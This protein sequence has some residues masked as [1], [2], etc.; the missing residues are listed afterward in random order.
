MRGFLRISYRAEELGDGMKARTATLLVAGGIALATTVSSPAGA[1]TPSPSPSPTGSAS[2]TASVFASVD[3]ADL[4][5]KIEKHITK[6]GG[7]RTGPNRISWE[8]QGVVMTFPAPAQA[9][10]GAAADDINYARIH[11]SYGN[12]CLYEHAL[13][14]RE[15]GAMIAFYDYN[16]YQLSDYGWQDIV[17]ALENNQ[18]ARAGGAIYDG[19]A[20]LNRS[21]AWYKADGLGSGNDRAD[22]VNVFP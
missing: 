16:L 14:D 18:S 9:T 6:Y 3:E 17:S 10:T 21:R 8:K 19:A 2:V 11:C 13:Y 7:K 20:T 5:S 1:T 15:G 4:S 22:Y 12:Y